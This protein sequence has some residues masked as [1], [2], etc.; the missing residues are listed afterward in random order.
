VCAK[1]IGT[2]FY[3]LRHSHVVLV[4]LDLLLAIAVAHINSRLRIGASKAQLEFHYDRHLK[5]A[6][7]EC[8]ESLAVWIGVGL[9]SLA[10]LVGY[11]T[12]RVQR[13]RRR[14]EFAVVSSQGLAAD[15]GIDELEVRWSGRT[16]S[17]P[18]ILVV[19]VVNTGDRAVVP[20][21]FESNL[22]LAVHGSASVLNAS[23]SSSRPRSLKPAITLREGEI[24]VLPLL[25]NA[26]DM[27]ELQILLDGA[28]SK[29]SMAGRIR[30]VRHI[31]ERPIP[32]PPGSGPEGEMLPFDKFMWTVPMIML[33]LG[34]LFLVLT[35]S[36]IPTAQKLVTIVTTSLVFIVG[37]PALLHRLVNKRRL[38]RP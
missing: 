27:F 24:H 38:W 34:V 28:P 29:V 8:V 16:M 22:T 37:Y 31:K 25:F 3:G 6:L 36:S 18:H 14:I 7:G 1:T 12:Y 23:L 13:A 2:S 26:G 20:E 15:K 30:E 5:P 32:Y 9:T 17:D 19:R 4:T 21:D 11:V 10:L 33:Y 35:A